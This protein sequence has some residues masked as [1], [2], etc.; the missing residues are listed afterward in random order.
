MV[1]YRS[2]QARS[3]AVYMVGGGG[4]SAP[5]YAYNYNA[6]YLSGIKAK[7]AAVAAGA[8]NVKILGWGDS[9]TVGAG[10]GTTGT[11]TVG[12]TG[13]F[14]KSYPAELKARI[15]SKFNPIYEVIGADHI[16]QPTGSA[17]I[18]AVGAYYGNV[19]F[20][21]GWTRPGTSTLGGAFV[22]ASV[23]GDVITITPSSPVN[24]IEV[25][26]QRVSSGGTYTVSDSTGVLATISTAGS[27]TGGLI[28]TVV[29]RTSGAN[30]D[31]I[32]ITVS[33]AGSVN[34]VLADMYN[35]TVKQTRVINGG[36]YGTTT[37]VQ[38]AS[39]LSSAP[40][41]VV[42]ALAPDLT[43]I[44]MGTN[45]MEVLTASAFQTNLQSMVNVAK[46]SGDVVLCWTDSGNPTSGWADRA[47][48]RAAMLSVAQASNCIMVDFAELMNTL[49]ARN[50]ADGSNGAN[51][52][53]YYFDGRHHT[54]AGYVAE[55]VQAIL[56]ALAP[57][58]V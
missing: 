1:G 52:A 25:Y 27:Q 58:L 41:S 54:N 11:A 5:S 51:Y 6:A 57:A 24:T 49:G 23:V 46:A 17:N 53:T 4:G 15:P 10:A 47:P 2:R 31:P 12:L 9:R 44:D 42:A 18:A 38:A 29:S 8:G 26:H 21:S 56:P 50:S 36:A 32:V 35:S 30:V 40:S 16:V 22:T 13:A 37:S 45:D 14:Q 19:T 39:T 3:R 33:V 48:F 20:S 28:K 55:V 34:F 7:L 43:I